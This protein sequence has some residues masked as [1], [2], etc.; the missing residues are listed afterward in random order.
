MPASL[1]VLTVHEATRTLPARI[2]PTQSLQLPTLLPLT[3]SLA[4]SLTL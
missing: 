4:V 3:F 1:P 2:V